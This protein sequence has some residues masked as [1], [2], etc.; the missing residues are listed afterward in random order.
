MPTYQVLETAMLTYKQTDKDWRNPYAEETTITN[1]DYHLESLHLSFRTIIWRRRVFILELIGFIGIVVSILIQAA[2]IYFAKGQQLADLEN[3]LKEHSLAVLNEWNHTMDVEG[4]RHNL[5]LLK[6]MDES[7][8][9]LVVAGIAGVATIDGQQVPLTSDE[10]SNMQADAVAC[11][12]LLEY[13]AIACKHSVGNQEMLEETL[14]QP[15]LYY[16][17]SLMPFTDA[18]QEHHGL[19]N[20]IWSVLDDYV[21]TLEPGN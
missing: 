10:T 5:D 15:V 19:K 20:P 14:R 4:R 3:G 12:N 7:G 11:L 18:L 13:V 2:T 16:Y 17:S 1:E 21:V 9:K 6:Q 8:L